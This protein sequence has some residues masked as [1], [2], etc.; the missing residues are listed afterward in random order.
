M[1]KANKDNAALIAAE[2][3]ELSLDDALERA[4]RWERMTPEEKKKC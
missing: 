2:T 3:G 4:R 1:A